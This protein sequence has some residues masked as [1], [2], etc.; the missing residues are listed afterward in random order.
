MQTLLYSNQT[1]GVTVECIINTVRR[2]KITATQ[3]QI[4]I[5]LVLSKTLLLNLSK[6]NT[7]MIQKT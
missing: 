7:L 6:I 4:K 2:Y 3:Q 5:I 1:I